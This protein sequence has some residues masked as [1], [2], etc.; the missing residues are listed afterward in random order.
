M[1]F[2]EWYEKESQ[3][4]VVEKMTAMLWKPGEKISG[5][6]QQAWLVR[7]EITLSEPLAKVRREFTNT[8]FNERSCVLAAAM[9]QAEAEAQD[10]DREWNGYARAA[11]GYRVRAGRYVDRVVV[12]EQDFVEYGT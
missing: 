8:L 4:V 6:P 2:R 12:R 9:L 3:R 1:I 11:D 5:W 7:H 10:R